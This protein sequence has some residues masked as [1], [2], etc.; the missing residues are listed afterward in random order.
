MLE[1]CRCPNIY[2]PD[3]IYDTGKSIRGENQNDASDISPTL[4]EGQ[5][6]NL[7]LVDLNL[8]TDFNRLL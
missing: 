7:P 4:Q 6:K 8:C 3:C 5:N 2:G 1:L